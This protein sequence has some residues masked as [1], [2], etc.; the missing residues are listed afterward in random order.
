MSRAAADTIYEFWFWAHGIERTYRDLRRSLPKKESNA[1]ALLSTEKLLLLTQRAHFPVSRAPSLLPPPSPQPPLPRVVSTACASSCSTTS[2]PSRTSGTS[3][4]SSRRSRKLT[5]RSSACV[6]VINE[7]RHLRVKN[8][9][10]WLRYDSRSGAHNTYKEFRELN[11]TDAMRSL[12]GGA[13]PFAIPV[14]SHTIPPS[15]TA[16]HIRMY[17]LAVQPIYILCCYAQTSSIHQAASCPK[18][19]LSCP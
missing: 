16:S 3:S 9:G 17:Y 6:H 4:A 13:S 11:M 8:F 19:A 15:T 7:R 18:A 2:S 10:I 14:H 5:A 12:Y 1:L